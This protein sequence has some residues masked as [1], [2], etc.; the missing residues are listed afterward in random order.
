MLAELE[1]TELPEEELDALPNL[2]IEYQFISYEHESLQEERRNFLS[3]FSPQQHRA[4]VEY[5][6]YMVTDEDGYEADR[7]TLEAINF[8]EN[9]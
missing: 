8:L 9:A 1:N 6:K 3:L 7:D 4:V 2:N 5:L